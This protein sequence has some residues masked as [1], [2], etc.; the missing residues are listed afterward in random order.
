MLKIMKKRRDPHPICRRSVE[1]RFPP[2]LK[3]IPAYVENDSP[4]L[5]LGHGEAGQRTISSFTSNAVNF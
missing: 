1:K 4:A 5:P 3:T 2:S